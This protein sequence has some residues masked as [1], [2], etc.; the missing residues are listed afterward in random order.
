MEQILPSN[1]QGILNAHFIN[2]H[3]FT[4]HGNYV[5]RGVL[6]NRRAANGRLVCRGRILS[7]NMS[8][9]VR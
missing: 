4:L 6:H 1:T 7:E 5:C 2:I 9:T 8:I 3:L